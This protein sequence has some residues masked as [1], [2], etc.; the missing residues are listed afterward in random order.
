MVSLVA[1]VQE[2]Q[3]VEAE[4]AEKMG[5]T[6]GRTAWGTLKKGDIAIGTEQ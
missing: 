5:V 6:T 4:E 2:V 3:N 1:W